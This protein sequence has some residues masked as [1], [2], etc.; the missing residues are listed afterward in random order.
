MAWKGLERNKLDYILTD[1]LPFEL[2]ELFSYSEFYMFLQEKNQKRKLNEILKSIKKNIAKDKMVFASRWSTMPLKYEITKGNETTRRLSLLQ[3]KSVLNIYF[4][5]ECYQKEIL[6]YFEQNH[7]FSIRYHKKN[8]DLYYKSRKGKSLAYFQS[9]AIKNG[10][11]LIQKRG[12]YFK[13]IP[14]QSINSFSESK[15]WRNAN[16]RFKYYGKIDY[17]SC[18]DSIYTHAFKWIIEG[19]TIDSKA[20]DGSNLFLE[21]D[22]ISQNINGHSS[23]GIVVGPEFSRMMAEILLQHID[24]E[25]FNLLKREGL[26]Y[27]VDYLA[28]RYV[29]DIFLC[30]NL[31]TTIDKIINL[32][33]KVSSKYLLMLNESKMMKSTTSGINKDWLGKTRRLSDDLS[34]LFY[35]YSR[36]EWDK[37]EKEKKYLVKN[38]SSSIDRIKDEVVTLV[39]KYGEDKRTI[40]SFLLSTLLKKISLKAEGRTLFAEGKVKKALSLI[41]LIMFIY[42]YF[43]SYVQTHKVLSALTFINKEMNFKNNMEN[44]LKLKRLINEYSFIFRDGNLFDLCDWFPFLFEYGISLD[45]KTEDIVVNKAYE[46]N[47]P[48]IWANVL[49]YSKYNVDF[50]QSVLQKVSTVIEENLDKLLVDVMNREEFWYVLIF[51]NCPYISNELKF[52]IDKKINAIK[53]EKPNN[54]ASSE[55]DNILFEFLNKQNDKGGK[56]KNSFFDW[57]GVNSFDDSITFKTYSNTLFKRYGKKS[58]LEASID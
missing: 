47:N 46:Y 31:E 40:V 24:M 12:D 32:Y 50:N 5:I 28:Y 17:K 30:A 43:P 3:P 6:Y 29:D 54:N 41:D 44:K 21:L 35:H 51:H 9:T 19:N 10:R 4:F 55:V 56:P 49:L 22:R 48:I 52:K 8:T 33:R 45:S 27:D 1:V 38:H 23:N 36:E 20:A 57:R 16:F 15:K 18:F 58:S 11:S 14:F 26:I 37:L 42:A 13:I 53:Q 7:V 39:K 25:V 34:N 2:S